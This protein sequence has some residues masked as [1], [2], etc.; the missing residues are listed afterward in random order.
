MADDDIPPMPDLSTG[1]D[2]MKMDE[3]G[4]RRWVERL[5]GTGV[6]A[7]SVYNKIGRAHV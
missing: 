6:A 1:L 4:R 7:D 2:P 5:F 3:A